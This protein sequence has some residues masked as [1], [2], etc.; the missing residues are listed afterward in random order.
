MTIWHKLLIASLGL[1]AIIV[2][3]CSPSTSTTTKDDVRAARE[4]F[5]RQD[6]EARQAIKEADKR[7]GNEIREAEK[8]HENLEKTEAK[9]ASEQ[10]RNDYVER[11]TQQIDDFETTV[12]ELEARAGKLE[13]EAKT[14]LEDEIARIKKACGNAREK[15]N[16]L[17]LADAEDWTAKQDD[18]ELAMSQAA[19]HID[20][21]QRIR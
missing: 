6:E 9:F 11:Q 12:A 4:A 8:A 19:E 17:K 1:A 20:E 16:E 7:V 21:A 2:A 10:A 14:A 5:E 15:L 18:V 13:G 3:G